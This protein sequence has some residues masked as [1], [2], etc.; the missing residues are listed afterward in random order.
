MFDYIPKSRVDNLHLY[1][2][3]GTDKSLVSKHILGPYWN[4]LVTLFPTSVAPNTIT[5]SGLVLVFFNF[6]TLA[7]VDPGLE[8]ATQL[9][10]DPIAHT[11]AL[12]NAFPKDASLLPVNPLFSNF[13]IPGAVAKIDF[14]PKPDTVGRCLPPWIFYTWALCLFAYQ[15]LDAIDGKQ[16]RRTGMAGPLG[17]LFD[18]GCDALN[19]TLECVL[20]CAALNLG[21][22]VWAPASLIA[23][24]ANFYLT[25]WEEFH[26][27]TL[28]LS[29]FSGPVEGILMIVFI[30]A[31]TGF[32]GGPL[33]WDRGI[34]NVTGLA[35]IPL[36][37]QT[38]GRFNLP[39]NDTF[40]VFALLG[41]LANIAGS[42]GNVINARKS[43]NQS[44]IT[45]LFGLVPLIAQ[46]GFNVYWM[47]ANRAFIISDAR[48]LLPFLAYW[49]ITFAYNVGLLIVAHVTKAP[50]PYWNVT[51]VWSV[52]FA[53]DANLPTSYIQIDPEM[54]LRVIYFSLVAAAALYFHFCYHVITTITQELGMACF[55]VKPP[56]KFKGT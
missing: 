33:F 3:S 11:H 7:Y 28:F 34:L 48:A 15:S 9:K 40:L 26:T 55:V 56:T 24:L 14:A 10:L 37:S 44:T 42:Y 13:A 49:G 22:S 30:Y 32:V 47:N 17:E 4:W 54:Q 35:K 21:R 27:G 25:T 19:T 45:P 39:L 31:L 43:R 16:A 8:C 12:N 20:C 29:A 1:K 51:I 23:T 41:L 53:I 38:L 2:Y 18:H 5:L 6:L 46:I 36:V 50:F 52:G